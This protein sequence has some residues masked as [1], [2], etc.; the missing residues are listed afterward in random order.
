MN[1][2]SNQE[3]LIKKGGVGNQLMEVQVYLAIWQFLVQE[4]GI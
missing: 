1:I 3:L 2:R 4:H